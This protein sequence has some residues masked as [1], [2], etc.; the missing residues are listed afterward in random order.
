MSTGKILP[1]LMWFEICQ[2]VSG[3]KSPL[4]SLSV[5]TFSSAKHRTRHFF[6]LVFHK[7]GELYWSLK[8]FF[9]FLLPTCRLFPLSLPF[10]FLASLLSNQVLFQNK[11][12]TCAS[13]LLFLH[14]F[15]RLQSYFP[16]EKDI[17]LSTSISTEETDLLRFHLL[18]LNRVELP[19][20]T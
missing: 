14:F 6:A 7:P 8:F 4:N 19:R 11:K 13:V 1:C 2:Y 10:P 3:R 16:N 17:N 12:Q 18:K 15:F 20:K 9:L 5:F